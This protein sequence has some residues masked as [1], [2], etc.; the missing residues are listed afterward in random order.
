[1]FLN[2]LSINQPFIKAIS[3]LNSNECFDAIREDLASAKVG[4][5]YTIGEDEYQHR[6]YKD[7]TIDERF[8]D[9]PLYQR[10]IRQL[11]SGK[12]DNETKVN[13]QFDL[14]AM[15]P[16]NNIFSRTRKREITTDWTQAERDTHTSIIHLYPEELE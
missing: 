3:A 12:N 2:T 7:A 8:K 5:Y 13:I 9:S 6:Y 4:T 14:S 16:M 1:M 11:S 10:I 15:S